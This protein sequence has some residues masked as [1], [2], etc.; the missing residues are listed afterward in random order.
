MS[1]SSI[2]EAAEPLTAVVSR[3]VIAE[4]DQ[5][6]PAGDAFPIILHLLMLRRSC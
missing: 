5:L 2:E 6:T 1:T 3:I 4:S